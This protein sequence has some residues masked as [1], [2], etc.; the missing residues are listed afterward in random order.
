MSCIYFG[1]V[2]RVELVRVRVNV[3]ALGLSRPGIEDVWLLDDS[4]SKTME[5]SECHGHKLCP[6]S[7]H[8][9]TDTPSKT[10]ELW[11]HG[12]PFTG[13]IEAEAYNRHTEMARQ[14]VSQASSRG[15]YP[16]DRFPLR[17]RLLAC[18]SRSCPPIPLPCCLI[19][20]RGARRRYP[21]GGGDE[22]TPGI[23]C[24]GRFTG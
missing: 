4:S 14:G 23:T 5:N 9:E 24:R 18:P 21:G 16:T 3:L 1:S 6:A 15:R 17:R 13:R 11:S 7:L 12:T 20:R 22:D 19:D 2:P 10:L 8:N